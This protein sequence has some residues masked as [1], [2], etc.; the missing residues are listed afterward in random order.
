MNERALCLR[1]ALSPPLCFCLV[2]PVV[3][4]Y[5]SRRQQTGGFPQTPLPI[6]LRQ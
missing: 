1:M 2:D 3:E 4:G 5:C 6:Q